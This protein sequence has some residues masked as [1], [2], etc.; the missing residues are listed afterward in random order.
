MCFVAVSTPHALGRVTARACRRDDRFV[1]VYEDAA[2]NMGV[3]GAG[4]RISRTKAARR[5]QTATCVQV[6]E[7]E[8]LRRQVAANGGGRAF[9]KCRNLKGHIVVYRTSRRGP[10]RLH[11]M[12]CQSRTKMPAYC[13]HAACFPLHG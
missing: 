11:S 2:M 9:G 4:D 6:D 5:K 7:N 10:I 3:H 12:L 8:G 13:D 1:P